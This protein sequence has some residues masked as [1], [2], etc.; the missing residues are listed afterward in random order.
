MN[1]N[2]TQE[3][4]IESLSK[5]FWDKTVDDDIAIVRMALLMSKELVMVQGNQILSQAYHELE[6]GLKD[7]S[8]LG[9]HMDLFGQI[10][11][12]DKFK[13]EN[14]KLAI[15]KKKKIIE[16]LQGMLSFGKGNNFSEILLMYIESELKELLPR[17]VT[18]EE[19]EDLRLAEWEDHQLSDETYRKSYASVYEEHEILDDG[20]VNIW[21]ITNTN[22]REG[23][24]FN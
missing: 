22:N 4:L 2:T 11:Q 13:K 23:D 10:L 5:I 19:F 14:L 1:E 18:R 16:E 8:E 3:K 17:K 9:Y 7:E 6:E 15:Q 24:K 20:H 21:E 12:M